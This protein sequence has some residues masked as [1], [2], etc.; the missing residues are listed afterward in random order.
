MMRALPWLNPTLERMQF[1][2][3][4]IK[5]SHTLNQL[6]LYNS[7]YNYDYWRD[8][9]CA[10]NLLNIRKPWT[11]VRLRCPL[12]RKYSDFTLC[13]HHCMTSEKQNKKPILLHRPV[14]NKLS[15]IITRLNN[16]PT[17]SYDATK[18]CIINKLNLGICKVETIRVSTSR[19]EHKIACGVKTTETPVRRVSKYSSHHPWLQHLQQ[20]KTLHEVNI[21]TSSL[22]NWNIYSGVNVPVL[23]PMCASESAWRG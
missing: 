9:T 23:L 15:L 11:L 8:R 17:E 14:L 3:F 12:A 10:R 5:D 7:S 21:R 1:F 4:D 16:W 13:R 22:Y 18:T 20:R 6:I 2:S 19:H